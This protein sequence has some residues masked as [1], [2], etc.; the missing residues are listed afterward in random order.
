[1]LKGGDLGR[2]SVEV[3]NAERGHRN[4][5]QGRGGEEKPEREDTPEMDGE[6]RISYNSSLGPEH[7]PSLGKE[8]SEGGGVDGFKKRN[9]KIAV[10]Q[11][12]EVVSLSVV[13]MG[14][15]VGGGGCCWGG[16]FTRG[17]GGEL[18][19]RGIRSTGSFVQIS[20]IFFTGNCH[21]LW[22][23]IKLGYFPKKPES[24]FHLEHQKGWGEPKKVKNPRLKKNNDLKRKNKQGG[25]GTHGG[26]FCFSRGS[27][28][29]GVFLKKK[30]V[31]PFLVEKV[32]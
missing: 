24:V 21:K 19:S 5:Y 9:G 28:L 12:P 23:G 3:K 10:G 1:M 8:P 6:E 11:H 14:T 32:H 7:G 29:N 16:W 22:G 17:G 18:R 27:G 20:T 25:G 13:I 15:G 30:G 4:S 26:W 31:N 2:K